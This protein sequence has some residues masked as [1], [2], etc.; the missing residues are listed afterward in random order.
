MNNYQFYKRNNLKIDLPIDKEEVLRYLG[1][2]D[3]AIDKCTEDILNASIIEIQSISDMS[4][5]YTVLPIKKTKDKILLY[6]SILK[7]TGEDILRHLKDSDKLALMATSLG[8]EVE[9]KIKQYSISNLTK[10]VIFD[11]CA[12]TMVEAL[13]DY[14]EKDIEAL[15]I[16]EGYQI[17][18]RY[19]PGYGD[20]PLSVQPDILSSLNAE[21]LIGLTV[22][23]NFIL[24]PRKSITAFIGFTKQGP[25]MEKN[26]SNCHLYEN[27]EYRKGGDPSC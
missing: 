16:K 5:I 7:L 2:K 6:N 22:T 9:K 20:L 15:A 12:T 21:K 27:C 13:C 3:N 8:F 18:S 4:Y 24:L 19:S 14:V 11:A 17:T 10:G 26:C 25:Q 1:Y 23:D